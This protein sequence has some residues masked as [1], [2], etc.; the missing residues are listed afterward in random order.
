[1]HMTVNAT[2]VALCAE[3]HPTHTDSPC[4]W[5]NLADLAS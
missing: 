4:A 2:T 3:R 1:M 5:T